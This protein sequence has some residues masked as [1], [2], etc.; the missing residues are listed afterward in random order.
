MPFD[1][2]TLDELYPTQGAYVRAV[3]RNVRELVADRYLTRADGQYLI[4]E[5]AQSE[6][7][8]TTG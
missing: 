2:A 6:I 5:A 8:G 4:N 3:R 1:Q 7:P